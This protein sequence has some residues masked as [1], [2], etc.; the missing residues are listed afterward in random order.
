MITVRI[1]TPEGEAMEP[2]ENC[3]I[4]NVDT[5]DGRRGILPRHQSIVLVLDIGR[6]EIQQG[7]NRLKYTI[8]GGMLYFDR[9]TDTATVLTDSIERFEDIDVQRAVRAKERAEQRLASKKET[10]DRTRAEI[11]LRKA[12]NRIRAAGSL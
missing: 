5:T 2:L 8:S 9:P 1:F 3:S 10:L 4:V 12:I 11:A 7:E 6:M